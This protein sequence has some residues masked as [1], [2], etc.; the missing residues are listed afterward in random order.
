MAMSFS[1]KFAAKKKKTFFGR[2]TLGHQLEIFCKLSL[3]LMGKMCDSGAK[4]IWYS[5]ANIQRAGRHPP[6]YNSAEQTA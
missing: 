3:N 2:A 6:G 1:V 4:L 5:L